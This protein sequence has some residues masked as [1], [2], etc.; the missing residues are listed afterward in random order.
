MRLPVS[1]E[2]AG[3]LGTRDVRQLNVQQNQIRMICKRRGNPT[4]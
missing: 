3:H 1:L 4:A 2:T